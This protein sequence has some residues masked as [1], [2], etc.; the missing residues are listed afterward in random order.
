MFGKN[1]VDQ[2]AVR[3]VATLIVKLLLTVPLP[4]GAPIASDNLTNR[5]PIVKLLNHG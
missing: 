3:R 1:S 4:I 2:T 5:R